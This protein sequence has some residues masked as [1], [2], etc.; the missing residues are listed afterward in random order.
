MPVGLI[1]VAQ[2]GE[3]AEV[4]KLLAMYSDFGSTLSSFQGSS[5]GLPSSC[6][7]PLPDHVRP[8]VRWG[9]GL[10]TKYAQWLVDSCKDGNWLRTSPIANVDICTL[11]PPV[12]EEVC[13]A[14]NFRCLWARKWKD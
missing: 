10:Q 6:N 8:G 5:S 4:E 2:T 13:D 1:E 7:P 9:A 11:V 12:P 14:S 3:V